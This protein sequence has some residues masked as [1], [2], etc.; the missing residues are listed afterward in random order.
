[1]ATLVARHVIILALTVWRPVLVADPDQSGT[2]E[3]HECLVIG[4]DLAG[5]CGVQKTA[6]VRIECWVAAGQKKKKNRRA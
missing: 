4:R 3:K 1:M 6:G 2:G 5:L